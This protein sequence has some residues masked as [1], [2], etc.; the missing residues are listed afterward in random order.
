VVPDR[1]AESIVLA[2]SARMAP[3]GLL[4]SAQ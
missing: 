2:D 1:G 3:S 4:A